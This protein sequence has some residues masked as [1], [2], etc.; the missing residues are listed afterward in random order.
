MCACEL[1]KKGDWRTDSVRHCFYLSFFLG[2]RRPVE[3]MLPVVPV[4]L[5]GLHHLVDLVDLVDLVVLSGLLAVEEPI[6][7][8]PEGR[9]VMWTSV[10]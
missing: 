6:L 10:R 7:L 8:F 9:S 4:I 3:L 2:G 1:M 5:L